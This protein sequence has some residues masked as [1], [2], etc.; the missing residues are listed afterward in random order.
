MLSRGTS[1]GHGRSSNATLGKRGSLRR[2]LRVTYTR[3]L[4]MP[5]AYLLEPIIRSA[6]ATH[7]ATS[8]SVTCESR[9]TQQRTSLSTQ[10]AQEYCAHRRHALK[11]HLLQCKEVCRVRVVCKLALLEQ[12]PPGLGVVLREE[13][14]IGRRAALRLRQE[15]CERSHSRATKCQRSARPLRKGSG[16]GSPLFPPA[17]G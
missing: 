8:A 7:S 12:E 4:A 17:S 6:V 2:A 10:R 9:D 15:Q 14:P 11:T 5:R 3:Q 13:Q 1:Y 16:S